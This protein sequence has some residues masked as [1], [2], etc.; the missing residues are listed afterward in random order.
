VLVLL[1]ILVIVG[2]LLVVALARSRTPGCSVPPP[3]LNL[4]AQLRTLG[5]LSQPLD[6]NDTR[7]LADAA[8]RA[9]T[10]LHPD[11]AGAS[12]SG[13]VRETAIAP[14]QHDAVVLPLSVS[15]G[16]AGQARVIG[17]VAFQLD[18]QGRAYY[19][20]VDDLLRSDPNGPSSPTFPRLSAAD[21]AGQLGI[22]GQ[23]RLVYRDS[24]F[25][26]LWQDPSTGRSVKAAP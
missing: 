25:T 14:A 23:P 13:V 8:V 18:C 17:L 10:A 16:S 4:P 24:L 11:L 2:S 3:D 5:E 6:T 20:G 15:A 12:A 7:T 22:S 9:A 21:A 1:G 19:F 26:P